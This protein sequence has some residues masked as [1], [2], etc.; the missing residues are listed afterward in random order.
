MTSYGHKETALN[1][2]EKEEKL[3]NYS[4]AVLIHQFRVSKY[5]Y[6]CYKRSLISV[7]L[8]NIWI[9]THNIR[10]EKS[11]CSTLWYFVDKLCDK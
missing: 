6:S 8:A 9:N 11:C 10:D 4:T 1:S 7:G 5:Y 2:L 3:L